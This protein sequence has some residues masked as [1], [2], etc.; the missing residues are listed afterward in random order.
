L[1]KIAVELERALARRAV[2][3]GP[4]Q[5]TARVLVQ[6]DGWRVADV[7]CTSGPRDRPFEERHAHVNIAIV[8]A[9]SFQYRSAA[10]RE[11]MTPGSLLLG[12]AG[13]YFECGHEY[14]GGDRCLAFG[15]AP[16]YFERL[17][18]DAGLRGPRPDFRALRLPPLRALSPLVARAC[19][20]LA[21]SADVPWEELS[22]QLAALTVR[23]AAGLSADA[24]EG[25]PNAVA[26]VTRTVR[27][28]ERHPDTGMALGSLA[29]EAG[30]SPYHFLRTF[31]RLTGVTPHQYVLRARLREAAMR[32]AL[33]PARVLDIALDCG[34]G[35]VSNF[36]RA[37]RAEFGVSPR[38]Y[39]R[40]P[41]GG[42]A[43]GREGA[44][45][46][47]HGFHRRLTGPSLTTRR[48]R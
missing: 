17:A 41:G 35:D 19:A 39:R 24:R 25:P 20:G 34:F 13:Q 18:A 2:N 1:A 27:M 10:G 48:A 28:I 36:N 29:R 37:F 47:I 44:R 15:Y 43:H 16:E 38:V 23:L 30:L 22:V 21:G 46:R 14:G 8:A 32:L 7:V 11:L 45:D 9:G 3:G 4:G 40:Q 42:S 26:R 5:T 6:G 31:E 33:E 12:T